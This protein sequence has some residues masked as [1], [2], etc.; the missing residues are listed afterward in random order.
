MTSLHFESTGFIKISKMQ[1]YEELHII[2][3]DNIP[4]SRKLMH[5]KVSTKEIDMKEINTIDELCL[6]F[7]NEINVVTTNRLQNV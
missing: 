2:L 7:L 1:I 4:H 5:Y 3:P 6:S